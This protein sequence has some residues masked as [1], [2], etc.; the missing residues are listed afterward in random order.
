MWFD[1]ESNTL[2]L[3]ESNAN[4]LPNH[5][6]ELGSRYSIKYARDA[7]GDFH[8]LVGGNKPKNDFVARK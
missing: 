2:Y 4:H 1:R 7:K 3:S 6:P 5:P 8:L